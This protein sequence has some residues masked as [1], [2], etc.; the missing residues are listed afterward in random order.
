MLR[1]LLLTPVLAVSLA[2]APPALGSPRAVVN[3]V[4]RGFTDTFADP[5]VIRGQDGLWYAYGTSDPLR[6]GEGTAHRIPIA[7]SSDLVNWAY[8]GDA[9]TGPAAPYVAPG[10]SYWAPDVRYLD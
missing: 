2:G 4:S 1:A 3:P 9:L 10:T 6:S 7:R 8:A 5:T